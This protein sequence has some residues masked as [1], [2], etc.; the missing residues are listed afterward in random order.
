[1]TIQY[2]NNLFQ[3]YKDY[4]E[5]G[6]YQ[7]EAQLKRYELLTEILEEVSDDIFKFL[8]YKHVTGVGEKINKVHYR[9]PKINQIAK[10]LD[11]TIAETKELKDKANNAVGT[12]FK[13]SMEQ[14]E[15]E[16]LINRYKDKVIELYPKT[17]DEQRYRDICIKTGRPD[18]AD[19]IAYN[20]AT[21]SLNYLKKMGVNVEKIIQEH[22]D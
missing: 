1:M 20:T 17:L 9:Y 18:L 6:T 14:Q 8:M 22:F 16:E 12:R 13:R 4:L 15:Q 21:D 10:K 5:Q 19:S 11:L 7:H 3:G 2:T